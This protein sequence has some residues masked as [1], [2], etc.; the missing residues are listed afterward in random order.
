MD[1]ALILFGLGVGILVGMT[2]MPGPNVPAVSFAGLRMLRM[3]AV[4][5]PR[6]SR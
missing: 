5:W 6:K 3:N 2:G 1:P 4:S